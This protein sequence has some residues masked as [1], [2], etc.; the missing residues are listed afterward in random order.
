MAATWFGS[1]ITWTFVEDR[2][3]GSARGGRGTSWRCGWQRATGGADP[4]RGQRRPA[5]AGAVCW[6]ELLA[7]KRNRELPVYHLFCHIVGGVVSPLL[8]NIALHGMEQVLGVKRD[9]RGTTVSNRAV[10]RYADDVAVFCVSRADAEEVVEIL[11]AWLAERGL[12]L[13]TEKTRIVHLSAGFDFLGFNIRQYKVSN[14]KS[15]YKLLITPSKQSVKSIRQRLRAEWLQLIG[16]NA[17]TVVR[18]LNTLIRGQ[19]NYYRI[20]VAAKTFKSL[21]RWMYERCVRYAKRNHPH[22][23]AAWRKAKYWGRLNKERKAEWVFGDKPSG[24]YLLQYAWF[25]IRGIFWYGGHRLLT[26]PTYSSTGRN[27]AEARAWN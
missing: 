19:A 2:T 15:G 6:A 5:E 12:A 3:G 23:S 13:S 10:V 7:P 16:H 17:R 25:K 18:K 9:K 27:E 26:T 4:I 24:A 22:K 8:A 11:S 21:D 20:A 1:N 14:S